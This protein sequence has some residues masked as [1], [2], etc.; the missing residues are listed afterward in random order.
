MFI[1]LIE[2]G[3]FLIIFISLNGNRDLL[4]WKQTSRKID[5]SDFICIGIGKN[6][7]SSIWIDLNIR[8]VIPKIQISNGR[9][10]KT[11]S[12]FSS[13]GAQI[14]DLL[15]IYLHEQKLLLLLFE[16]ERE[17]NNKKK[18][19]NW[20]FLQVD[21]AEEVLKKL[22]SKKKMTKRKKRRR[23]NGKLFLFEE[24]MMPS[25]FSNIYVIVNNSF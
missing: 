25:F 3:I 13:D 17:R 19:I 16:E 15:F 2:R 6:N 14:F 24:T 23:R 7:L 8:D 21:W 9:A 20:I 10:N 1:I 4:W 22:E 18:K 12:I 11:I 5:F